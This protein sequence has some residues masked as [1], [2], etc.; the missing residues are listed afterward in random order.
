MI[1]ASVPPATLNTFPKPRRAMRLAA[2]LDCSIAEYARIVETSTA[3]TRE[4]LIDDLAGSMV[5]L[6]TYKP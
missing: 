6:I 2:V 3:T 4:V 1:Q 5:A